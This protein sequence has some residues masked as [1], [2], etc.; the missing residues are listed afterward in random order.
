[1]QGNKLFPRHEH[2]IGGGAGPGTPDR[3]RRDRLLDASCN[4]GQA[5]PPGVALEAE[6]HV[7]LGDRRPALGR[8]P[9]LEV[10]HRGPDHRPLTRWDGRTRKPHPVTGKMVPD[11][12][13]RVEVMRLMGVQPAEWPKAD[14]II[15][16]PPFIAGKDLREV[17]GE[18]YAR[19]LWDVYPRLPKAADYVMYW[20]HRAAREV[21][22]ARARRFGLI[23]TKSL[24][25]AFNRRVVQAHL[26]GVDG[27]SIAL[28]FQT[29]HGWTL[30]TL[31]RCVSR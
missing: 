4:L 25:Q 16:N 9:R 30:L 24:A 28:L 10:G 3:G 20:W 7:L 31:P 18:G 19:A 14:F 8:P 27:I 21:S 5:P 13:A 23:T 11:E 6:L 1:M 26:E 12:E 22:V 15:G 29:I 2:V 17:R